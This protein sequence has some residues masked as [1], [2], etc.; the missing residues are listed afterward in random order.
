MAKQRRMTSRQ[1]RCG[2]RGDRRFFLLNYYCP[3]T[4]EGLVNLYAENQSQKDSFKT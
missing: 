2:E 4:S 1:L 3:P